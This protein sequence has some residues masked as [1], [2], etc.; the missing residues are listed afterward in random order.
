MNMQKKLKPVVTNN[1]KYRHNAS[2][3]PEQIILLQALQVTQDPK[4]LRQLMGV[5]TVADVYRTLDK[6]SI[7]KEYHEALSRAGFSLDKVVKGIAL[8]A[9]TSEKD[10]TRLKA[11]QTIL[12]SI[13]LDKYDSGDT[14]TGGTWEEELLKSVDASKEKTPELSSPLEADYEVAEVQVPEKMKK[15]REE[16]D[17]LTKSI[18]GS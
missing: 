5:K 7:R 2:Q 12:K 1:G 14:P 13:G 3:K 11:Y 9:E 4:K 8:I 17:E 15:L 6:M 10:D 18:Y 16:E